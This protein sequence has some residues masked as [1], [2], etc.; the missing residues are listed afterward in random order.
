MLQKELDSK[1]NDI[2]K[3]VIDMLYKIGPDRKGHPGPAL[4]IAEILA[5]L[6]FEVLNINP[7]NPAWPDRDRFILSKG[8]ACPALYAALALKGFFKKEK[9]YTL[10]HI[11]SILQGHPDMRKTPGID[12]TAG[13]LGH[14]LAAGIGI[15]LGARMDG[16]NYKVYVV[17]G[18]G[19]TQEG[20]IWEAAMY[21][22]NLGLGNLVV[23]IDK[24]KFQSCDEVSCIVNIDPLDEKLKAFGW[25]VVKCNGHDVKDLLKAF[26]TTAKNKPLAIIAETVKGKGV[27]FMENDN[28]WHQKA[29]TESQYEIAMKELS[30]K[31]I[32]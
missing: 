2:R 5:C 15:A 7:N 11:D 12:M 19:E 27:S 22:G 13:S 18:D 32:N 14:G 23:I 6:Y 16:K 10:R 4:S 31:D 25:E 17:I 20:L 30:G 28:S 3:L 9:L 21:A 1:A 29:I 24:N 8:H 26:K